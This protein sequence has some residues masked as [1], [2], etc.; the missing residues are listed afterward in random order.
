M[1]FFIAMASLVATAG[2]G[3][4][5]PSKVASDDG[6]GTGATPCGDARDEGTCGARNDCHAV[7]Q[8][9]GVV[10]CADVSGC[11]HFDRCADGAKAACNGPTDEKVVLCMRMP[12]ICQGDNVT[13]YTADC[14]EGCVHPNECAP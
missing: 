1:M 7:F 2:C 8:P 4:G 12:P 13:S 3:G 6:G 10:N 14:Y 5:E 11:V 9:D